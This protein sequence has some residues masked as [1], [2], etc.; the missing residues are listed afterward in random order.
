MPLRVPVG[1]REA[2]VVLVFIMLD[3]HPGHFLHDCGNAVY[4][5]AVLAAFSESLDPVLV[6]L[7]E[8]LGH[9]THDRV[10]DLREL[11]RVLPD[12]AVRDPARNDPQEAGLPAR[13]L[14]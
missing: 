13:S 1:L 14:G 7:D 3:A 4:H 10:E 12:Q 5:A 11:E 6:D 9:I 2:G 8:M